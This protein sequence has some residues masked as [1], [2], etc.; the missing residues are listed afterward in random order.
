MRLENGFETIWEEFKVLENL[1]REWDFLDKMD[2]EID[3][4]SKCY[5]WYID[6]HLDFKEDDSP[7]FQRT[8]EYY[9]KEFE[10]IVYSIEHMEEL[11]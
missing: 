10:K 6:A 5:G 8:I 4:L 7:Q 2:L 1:K 3:W 11:V 9:T